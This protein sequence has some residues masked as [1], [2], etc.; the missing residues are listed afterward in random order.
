MDKSNC[1]ANGIDECLILETMECNKCNFYKS[2]N[3]KMM[4]DFETIERLKGLGY[5]ID[6]LKKLPNYKAYLKSL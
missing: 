3:K 2:K 6:L 4:D 5:P 1:F